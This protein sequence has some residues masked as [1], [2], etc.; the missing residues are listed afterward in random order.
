[1]IQNYQ[2]ANL[3]AE[4]QQLREK[5]ANCE[6]DAALWQQW[7]PWLERRLGDLSKYQD[8]ATKGTDHASI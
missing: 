2:L 4:V 5:L 1:M 7:K 3:N 8:A 6:K